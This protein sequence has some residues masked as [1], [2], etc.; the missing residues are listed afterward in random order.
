MA[1]T[2]FRQLNGGPPPSPRGSETPASLKSLSMPWL[3]TRHGGSRQLQG[4]QKQS[5]GC[6]QEQACD[7]PGR[8]HSPSAAGDTQFS[9]AAGRVLLPL[10]SL[11]TAP[12]TA[13]ATPDCH[14]HLCPCSTSAW[15]IFQPTE[16]SFPRKWG[17]DI[18]REPRLRPGSEVLVH[19]RHSCHPALLK[20]LT[21]TPD[22]GPRQS[23][24]F[25]R[26]APT[27]PQPNL[28]KEDKK[29]ADYV[30]FMELPLGIREEELSR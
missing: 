22:L 7:S 18:P 27:S 15:F 6:K 20:G 26:K 1:I 10:P 25:P 5:D 9:V 3:G 19:L 24:P 23:Q 2:T 4:W 30:F 16:R 29:G 12:L 13:T 8:S 28:A 21:N 11:R 17:N 14:S